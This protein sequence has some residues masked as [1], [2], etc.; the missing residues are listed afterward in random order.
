MKKK[1][2]TTAVLNR[3]AA[4]KKAIINSLSG[5]ATELRDTLL[6]LF[7]ELENAEEEFDINQFKSEIESIIAKYSDVPEAT[8]DAIAKAV[9]GVLKRVQNSLPADERLTPAVK[10]QIA[11]AIFRSH[12][13]V[14]AKNAVARVLAKNGIEGLSFEASVDYVIEWKMED[15]NPLF[16]KLKRTMLSKFFYG[17]INHLDKDQIAHGWLKT[18]EG[19]KLIQQLSVEGKRI[20]V[21]Y[22]YKRQQFAFKDLDEIEQAGQLTQFLGMIS[23][24]LD[25]QIVNGIVTT[26]LVGD[27]VND[28]DDKIRTFESIGT[29][30][31]SDLFTRVIKSS[32]AALTTYLTSIGVGNNTPAVSQRMAALKYVRDEIHNPYGKEVVAVMSRRVLSELSPRIVAAGGD[33]V[34]RSKEEVAAELGVDDIFLTDVMPDSLAPGEANKA[35]VIFMIPDGYWYKE[36]KSVDVAYPTYEKNVQNLQKE[37]NAG[38]GIHDL[39]STAVYIVEAGE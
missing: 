15:L 17:E 1:A 37:R 18:K 10:N 20:E 7:D 5:D 23:R 9:D 25:A 36:V 35:A 27:Q 29:K 11:A 24:E 2:L 38:G 8:A 4:C 32:D 28:A 14:D 12:D 6:A 16:A 31:T 26:I 3:V 39:L 34:F 33:F 30:T 13:K 22:I 21:D 19:E